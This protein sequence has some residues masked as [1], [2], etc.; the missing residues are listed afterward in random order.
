MPPLD[1]EAWNLV[2]AEIADEL[3][4]RGAELDIWCHDV[5]WI[6][7][8]FDAGIEVALASIDARVGNSGLSATFGTTACHSAA[9][10][11]D[12]VGVVFEEHNCLFALEDAGEIEAWTNLE[13][14]G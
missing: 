8:K 12:H 6:K 10:R 14:L 1:D 7:E 9:D 11:V 2:G 4:D 5:V 13:K 3:L